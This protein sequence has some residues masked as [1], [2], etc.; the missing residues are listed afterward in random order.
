MKVGED[1]NKIEVIPA[2]PYHVTMGRRDDDLGGAC[3]DLLSGVS[4]LLIDRRPLLPEAGQR[5][6]ASIGE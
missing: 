2:C 1:R 6:S 5:V 4:R 3:N